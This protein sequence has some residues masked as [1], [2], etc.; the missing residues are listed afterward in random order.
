MRHHAE[1]TASELHGAIRRK[2][3]AFAGNKRLK[4]YGTL[5]C[6]SGKRMH[7]GN[8]IFFLSEEEAIHNGYRPCG[9][10][11]KAAYLNWVGGGQ[12]PLKIQEAS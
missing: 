5:Q 1:I 11:M 9:H 7:P 2:E 6:F 10:C 8:R 3:I 12:R 4:I